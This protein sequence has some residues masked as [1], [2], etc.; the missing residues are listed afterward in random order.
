MNA[1]VSFILKSIVD[2]VYFLVATIK[3]FLSLYG[4]MLFLILSNSKVFFCQ[5]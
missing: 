4:P 3:V 2:C 1:E 5:H